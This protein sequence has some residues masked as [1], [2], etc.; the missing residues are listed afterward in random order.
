MFVRLTRFPL[1]PDSRAAAEKVAAKNEKVLR[2]LPGNLSTVI[3]LAD[4]ELVSFT[5]WDSEEHAAAVTKAAR[6][7]AQSDLDD[8]LLGPPTTTTARTLVHDVNR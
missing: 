4:D 1:K 3:Y 8:V 5:T 2:E 6:D 7:Q